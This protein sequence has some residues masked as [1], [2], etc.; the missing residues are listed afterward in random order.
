[1]EIIRA[2]PIKKWGGGGELLFYKKWDFP[3]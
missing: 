1:M 2:I 3:S